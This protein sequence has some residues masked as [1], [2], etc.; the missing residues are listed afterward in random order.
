[1]QVSKE[2]NLN[3]IRQVLKLKTIS[4]NDL[5]DL[6]YSLY[7]HDPISDSKMYMIPQLAYRIQELAYGEQMRLPSARFSRQ[8][9]ISARARRRP[10]RLCWERK[11]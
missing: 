5:R 1:M 6:W 8:L 3:T 7:K 9:M 10:T 11:L 2:N 4:L